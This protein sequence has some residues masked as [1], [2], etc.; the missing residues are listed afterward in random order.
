VALEMRWK[1]TNTDLISIYLVVKSA[2]DMFKWKKGIGCWI[3]YGGQLGIDISLQ[4]IT[5]RLE[6]KGL[7]S[8]NL[9]NFTLSRNNLI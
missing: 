6:R 8:Q 9:K 5:G 1:I 2:I 7:R 4:E 3:L